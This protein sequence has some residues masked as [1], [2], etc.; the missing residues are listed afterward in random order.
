MGYYL[1]VN[2]KFFSDF[3]EN[4]LIKTTDRF[5]EAMEIDTA[6]LDDSVDYIKKFTPFPITILEKMV[7][8]PEAKAYRK[9]YRKKKKEAK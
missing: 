8:T 4:R 6:Y 3:I 9:H 2:D 1:I 5:S 7:D